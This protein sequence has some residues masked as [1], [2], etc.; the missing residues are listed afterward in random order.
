L[1][2]PGEKRSTGIAHPQTS[3]VSAFKMNLTVQGEKGKENIKL[4]A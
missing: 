4:E 2:K 1:A 3:S